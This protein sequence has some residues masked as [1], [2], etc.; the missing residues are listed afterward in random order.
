MIVI[1]L[2]QFSWNAACIFMND[3]LALFEPGKKKYI[4]IYIYIYGYNGIVT[5]EI[6][7]C[8]L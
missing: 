6:A 5:N 7:Q 8:R 3:K 4:Y 2:C 1:D